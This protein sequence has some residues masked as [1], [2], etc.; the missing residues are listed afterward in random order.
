MSVLP[1]VCMT[2]DYYEDDKCSR[3]GTDRDDLDGCWCWVPLGFSHGE[4][5]KRA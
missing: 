1:D 2:C 5:E 3:D 4:E